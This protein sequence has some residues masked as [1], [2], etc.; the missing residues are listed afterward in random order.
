MFDGL[1]S[2]DDPAGPLPSSMRLMPLLQQQSPDPS[3]QS[4]SSEPGGQRPSSSSIFSCTL[5]KSSFNMSIYTSKTVF[6]TSIF[7]LLLPLRHMLW[8]SRNGPS[9]S[10][11]EESGSI[12]LLT[13]ALASGRRTLSK[14]RSK[15][16]SED[17]V[18]FVVLQPSC[19]SS[20]YSD[21]WRSF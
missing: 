11:M 5:A 4:P 1:A 9:T 19:A 21:I 12:S 15:N 7:P 18:G 8:Y 10:H 20:T 13:S 2:E 16:S 14:T 17:W 6:M 3:L